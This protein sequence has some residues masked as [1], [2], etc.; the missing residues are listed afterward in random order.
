MFAKLFVSSLVGVMFAIRFV[1]LFV[2]SYVIISFNS[3][4]GGSVGLFYYIFKP[5]PW[6]FS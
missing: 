6:I 4:D 1:C 5:I 2:G 3:R